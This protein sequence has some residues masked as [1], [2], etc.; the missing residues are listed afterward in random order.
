MGNDSSQTTGEK[1]I[2]LKDVRY[3]VDDKRPLGGINPYSPSF[4]TI[5]TQFVN[6]ITQYTDLS[7]KHKI[8]DIGCGTGRLVSALINKHPNIRCDGLDINKDYVEYCRL[9]YT[10]V[11][12]HHDIYHE[13]YNPAGTIDQHRF[14]LPYKDK[15]YDTITILGV[16]NHVDILTTCRLIEE[17]SRILKPRGVLVATVLLLNDHSNDQI[18]KQLTSKP[19]KFAYSDVDYKYEVLDRKYLNIAVDE[20]KI[21]QALIKQNLIIKEPIKYGAWCNYKSHLMGHDIIIAKKGGWGR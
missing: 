12:K 1:V 3:T 19:F 13:E 21:R 6:V 15:Q 20:Q 5:G 10:G 16:L 9:K 8:L 4:S 2:L 14:T 7:P 18:E 17:S 11:F